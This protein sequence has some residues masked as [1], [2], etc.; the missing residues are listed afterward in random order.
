[1]RMSCTAPS[2]FPFS[3]RTG[4]H[5]PIAPLAAAQHGHAITP[6]SQLSIYENAGH[7]P[8]MEDPER[9]NRELADFVARRKA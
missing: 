9:F 4:G 7:A 5:D 8:F 1:M 6:K 3:S 2:T